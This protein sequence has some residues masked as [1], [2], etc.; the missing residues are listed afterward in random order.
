MIV[1]MHQILILLIGPILLLSSRR[2][3][4]SRGFTHALGRM[5]VKTCVN[6]E[7]FKHSKI[8]IFVLISN[9]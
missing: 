9:A 1:H 8:A 4:I 3:K 5:F 2:S 7:Y 6:T